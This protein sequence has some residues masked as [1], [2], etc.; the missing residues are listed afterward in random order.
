MIS[1]QEACRAGIF[2][3]FCLSSAAPTFAAGSPAAVEQVRIN[4]LQFIG[5]HNSYHVRD[6][7]KPNKNFPDWS[8]SH[9][10]LDVQLEHGVR[11]FE[12]DLQYRKGEFLVFHVAILDEGSTCHTLKEGLETV[13]KWSDAHPRHLPISFLFELKQE[14]PTLDPTIKV[15]DSAALDQLD[16]ILR[17]VFPPERTITPDDVRGSAA[18]LR[19]AV[20]KSDWPRLESARGKVFYILHDEKK[21][22]E[23][24][25]RDHP[26]LR[27]R[28]MFVR[29]SENRE[30]AATLVMDSPH[31]PNIPR[32]VKAG[33]FIRT[34]ADSGL[35]T[36]GHGP[37]ARR[38]AAFDSG[39]QIVSTDYPNGEAQ[40]T[41]GFVV[42]FPQAAPGR[43]NPINGPEGLR[44]QTIGR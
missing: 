43:V 39:A 16:G 8:Y 15:P 9:A 31:D 34:R 41:T 40:P 26:S 18:T 5:T 27:G 44:G 11:S 24:Y 25:T 14:G 38:D 4:Q 22:R 10:P 20:L 7:A 29:S 32:L 1:L 21:E 6:P 30:D 23:L 12:L 19:E 33:Y 28:V 13:R 36:K 37:M 2:V 35:K 3:L 42:E 17:S